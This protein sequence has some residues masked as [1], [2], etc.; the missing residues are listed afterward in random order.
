MSR[1]LTPVMENFRTLGTKRLAIGYRITRGSDSSIFRRTNH[2][3]DLKIQVATNDIETFFSTN[4]SS[5]SWAADAGVNPLTGVLFGVYDANFT[6]DDFLVGK[7]NDSK[8]DV[9]FVDWRF[10]WAGYLRKDVYWFGDIEK[11]I[12]GWKAELRSL[13]SKVDVRIGRV[14]ERECDA[15]FGDSRCG[16]DLVPLKSGT[17]TVTK[18]LSKTDGSTDL[19]R[20][21]FES[22]ETSENDDYYRFG[23]LTW[24]TGNNAITGLDEYDVKRYKQT[25]GRID[26]YLETP[27]DIEVGDTLEMTPGCNKKFHEHCRK[28]W[29]N[30]INHRGQHKMKDVE[31]ILKSPNAKG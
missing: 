30:E 15:T 29:N 3:T 1:I 6:L 11:S 18:V 27:Y 24:L 28:L 17:V 26:L 31:A 14:W 16:V 23:K 7:W 5:E 13:P 21:T 25:N 22:S 2:N 19:P 4:G 8:V 12:T 20:L 10:P 9:F